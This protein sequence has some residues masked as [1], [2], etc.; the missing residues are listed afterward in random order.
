MKKELS[1]KLNSQMNFELYSAYIYMSMSAYL[2]DVN[3]SGMAHWARLQA[4]EEFEHAMKFYN[5]ML[6]NNLKPVF[7]KINKPKAEWQS[8]IEIFEDIYNHEKLVTSKIH[9]LI[10]LSSKIEEH[11]TFCFL[12]WFVEEQIEEEATAKSILER[13]NMTENIM[14]TLNVDK[15]LGKRK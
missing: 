12:Q 4:K 6:K 5:F 10:K 13:L 2:E 7:E 3:L 1:D 15:E 11:A 8:S 14:N 9:E